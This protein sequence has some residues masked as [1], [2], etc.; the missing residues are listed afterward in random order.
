MA[1]APNASS[2]MNPG[3]ADLAKSFGSSG[4]AESLGGFRPRFFM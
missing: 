2:N 1:A 4:N 3:V